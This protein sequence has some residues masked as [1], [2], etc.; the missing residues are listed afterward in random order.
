MTISQIN[1][2]KRAR[3]T[4]KPTTTGPSM[5]PE[6]AAMLD[7]ILA[8]DNQVL[9][10]IFAELSEIEVARCHRMTAGAIFEKFRPEHAAANAAFLAE[11]RKVTGES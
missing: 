11:V 7:T 5:L 10:E 9:E 1:R 6:I 4:L 8:A 2:A 3:D